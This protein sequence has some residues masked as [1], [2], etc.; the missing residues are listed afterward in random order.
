MLLNGINSLSMDDVTR[1]GL[2]YLFNFCKSYLFW[3]TIC[4]NS[5]VF[6]TILNVNA[7]TG[8]SSDLTRLFLSIKSP[9]WIPF[10]LTPSTV[11]S[12]TKLD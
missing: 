10:T 1:S 12:P 9:G 4:W 6:S 8:L 11:G 7:S 5:S 3:A 2:E